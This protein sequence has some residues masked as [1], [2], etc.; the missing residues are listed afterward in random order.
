MSKK[1][2]QF[3]PHT[4]SYEQIEHTIGYKV[5]R[6]ILYFLSSLFSGIVIFF[7]MVTFFP[8]PRERQLIQEK[9]KILAQ[10]N[11]LDKQLDELSLVLAD[12]QQRDDNLYRVIYQAEPIPLTTR[13]GQVNKSAYYDQLAEMTNSQLVADITY[14]ADVLKKQM[15]VQS[16]SYDEIVQ[17]AKENESRLEHL[18]AIQ[19]VLNKDLKRTASGYGWRIDPI[20]HTR[21]FHEGMDFSAPIGTDVYATG[22]AT[23]K[24]SGWKSGYGNCVI[25]DHGFG[26]ETLYGHLHKSFVRAGQKVKRRDIIALVGNTGKSTG[27]HLHYEVHFRGNVMNPQ[28]YYFQDLS[29]EEYDKMVQ[30]SE[31]TGQMFD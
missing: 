18:P 20:Y 14:K 8:S 10:Y 17:L 13:L 5:K 26:Y 7:I 12:L 19:P 29:P 16:K 9:K 23:V 21:R 11:L 22:N 31:N 1:K 15:Y 25:L 4:L 24:F 27:P 3:N 2:F 28:N 30:L 6:S